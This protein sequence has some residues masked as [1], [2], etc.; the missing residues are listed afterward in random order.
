VRELLTPDSLAVIERGAGQL[1]LQTQEWAQMV[2]NDPRFFD[3]FHGMWRGFEDDDERT[4][5]ASTGLTST[6]GRG[7]SSER[8]ELLGLQVGG[9]HAFLLMN[10]PLL[11]RWPEFP[12]R[13]S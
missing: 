12:D 1:P 11:G 9:I 4:P 6:R 5:L 3:E 2:P 7:V 13:T 8:H 10:P